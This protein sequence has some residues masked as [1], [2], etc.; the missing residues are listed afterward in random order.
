MEPRGQL[1]YRR[2]GGTRHRLLPQVYP[3]LPWLRSCRTKY[4]KVGP[5]DQGCL[6]RA[7]LAGDRV[8]DGQSVRGWGKLPE[9]EPVVR[10]RV[11]TGVLR[12]ELRLRHHGVRP[13]LYQVPVREPASPVAEEVVGS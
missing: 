12:Q 9:V 10:W 5:L 11:T 8:I 2:V 1:L 13:V 3:V 6:R 7:A 4:R